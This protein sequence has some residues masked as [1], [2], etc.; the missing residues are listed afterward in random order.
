MCIRGTVSES[1]GANRQSRLCQACPVPCAS[2]AS[3][4]SGC[5][6]GLRGP[7]FAHRDPVADPQ[8]LNGLSGASGWRE[9]ATSGPA[10]VSQPSSSVLGNRPL[11]SSGSAGHLATMQA[12]LETVELG[13]KSIIHM[14]Q[15]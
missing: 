6:E 3:A 14:P 10:L 15:L 9:W 1:I 2:I 8:T 4:M 7:H 5:R 12:S 11:Q 13:N